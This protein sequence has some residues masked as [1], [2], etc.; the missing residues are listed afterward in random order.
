MLDERLNSCLVLRRF[1]CPHKE[2]MA[3]VYVIAQIL[4][5]EQL[6]DSKEKCNRCGLFERN[7]HPLF[8]RQSGTALPGGATVI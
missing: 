4:S 8:G 2:E 5:A 1:M 7:L 3:R 6:A